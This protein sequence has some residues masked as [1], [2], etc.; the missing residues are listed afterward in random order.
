M[1]KLKLQYFGHLMWRADSFEKTLMLGKIE[2]R[3]RRQ[4]QDEMV[5]WHHW[6]NGDEF[7]WTLGVGD[8]QRGLVCC[9]SWDP[10]ESD[11]TEWL[12]LT[13]LNIILSKNKGSVAVFLSLVGVHFYVKC[14]SCIY[15][16]DHMIFIF[17]F[18]NVVYH[19]DWFVDIEPH[20][21]LVHNHFN[22]LLSLNY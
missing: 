6:L 18:D 16:Y 3:R 22:V 15:S 11:M 7:W 21:I 19:I 13:E 17:N 20:L 12:N 8:G 5:G 4:R 9:S 1:L 2:A 14:F 10:K